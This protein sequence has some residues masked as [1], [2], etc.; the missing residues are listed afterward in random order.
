[1]EN[2]GQGMANELETSN[3]EARELEV[4]IAEKVVKLLEGE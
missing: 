2:S 3:A 1:M 4:R